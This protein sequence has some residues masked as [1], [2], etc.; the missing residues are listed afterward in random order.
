MLENCPQG[1][2]EHPLTSEC[3]EDLNTDDFLAL[4]AE[5]RDILNNPQ[6]QTASLKFYGHEEQGPESQYLKS[7]ED[8]AQYEKLITPDSDDE[9]GASVYEDPGPQSSSK[10]EDINKAINDFYG[11]WSR[12]D[13]QEV[14]YKT[15]ILIFD[16]VIK[17]CRF[18]NYKDMFA[19]CR[20]K[21]HQLSH[22]RGRELMMHF[23][24]ERKIRYF[25]NFDILMFGATTIHNTA[26]QR[27]LD[28]LKMEFESK[29]SFLVDS[30]K[31]VEEH[32]KTIDSAHEALR[33]TINSVSEVA[34]GLSAAKRSYELQRERNPS[35][36]PDFPHTPKEVPNVPVADHKVK[37][38]YKKE[39]LAIPISHD[40]ELVLSL[41]PILNKRL[42]SADTQLFEGLHRMK[43]EVFL[44]AL[45][46][47]WVLLLKW[48]ASSRDPS[49]LS[50]ARTL[51]PFIMESRP[52][53]DKIKI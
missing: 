50:I 7:S 3:E 53:P 44:R 28:Q 49:S 20:F 24:S 43:P 36:A 48:A 40:N 42:T 2:E 19:S 39:H 14:I 11:F 22:E 30:V 37:V 1:Q 23:I 32:I 35:G 34:H 13:N 5:D 4:S 41:V 33:D 45:N 16:F 15:P 12:P 10:G 9:E 18:K 47:P 51:V 27:D 6:F 26:N 8:P 25:Q 21:F 31:T 38:V 29:V 17:D 52:L 46:V